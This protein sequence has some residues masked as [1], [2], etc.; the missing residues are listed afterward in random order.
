MTPSP[1][2]QIT[3]G[4]TNTNRLRRVD[5]WI[6]RHPALRAASADPLVVDLG[7]GASG[8]TAF[9]LEARL[10]S[11]RA[12]VEVLGLEIDP[13]RVARANAQLSELRRG[14]TGFSPDARVSFAR[15][16]FEVPAPRA[17]TV[18]RAFNVLR[19]YGEED[20]AA[21]WQR[22][23]ARL[24]PGGMLVEGTCDE[25]GRVCTWVEVGADAAPRSLTLSLRLSA[26]QTPSIAAE[27]L[28]KALIH[29]NI[30]GERVHDFLRALDTQWGQ[31]A[32]VSPFGPVHRW[33]T[34]LEGMVD[35]GWPL[36]TPARWR[37]GEVTVPWSAVAPG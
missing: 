11:A 10:R 22:M 30:P 35:A 34:A 26:L 6:A 21:A 33:R 17:P 29:R 32:V 2:G 36:R 7:Y 8:V 1:I 5:R 12:D 31:A 20:V 16:G 19:Q 4:T 23:T 13:A 25:I 15:G 27:R 18:V 24:A 28:P 14:G 37:L 3:R 9:E